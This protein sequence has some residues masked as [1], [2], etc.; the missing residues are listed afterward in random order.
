MFNFVSWLKVTFLKVHRPY[1]ALAS[2]QTVFS[3]DTTPPKAETKT[4]KTILK[5]IKIYGNLI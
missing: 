1:M 5:K 3:S 4:S 2:H